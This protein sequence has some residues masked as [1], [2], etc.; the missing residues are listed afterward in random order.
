M[1]PRQE[2]ICWKK[3]CKQQFSARLPEVSISRFIAVCPYCGTECVISLKDCPTKI[4]VFRQAALDNE[5]TAEYD[6]PEVIQTHK[7]E[8]ST[9]PELKT[10]GLES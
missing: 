6:L 10:Q 7:K 3:D 4:G 2:L 5:I 9:T 1:K 8:V